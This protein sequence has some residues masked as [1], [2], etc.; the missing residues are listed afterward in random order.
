MSDLIEHDQP[1]NVER[2]L[3]TGPNNTPISFKIYQDIYHQI[4]GKTEEISKK[5]SRSILIEFSDIEQLHHKVM[6]LREIHNVV[7]CNETITIFHD[8]E[9]K[10]NFTS[11]EKF[12]LYNS[13]SNSPTTSVVLQYNF[14]II[15]SGLNTPR[16][17]VIKVRLVSRAALAAQMAGEIPSYMRGRILSMLTENTA[18][19][20]IEYSDYIVAR[21]YL[22]AFDEWI[23]GCN[24]TEKSNLVK[25]LQRK[26]HLFKLTVPMVLIAIL[27][28]FANAAIPDF[29]GIG[30]NSQYAARFLV[31]YA[32]AAY[33]AVALGAYL[34]SFMEN[35][36]DS[37][38]ILS[39][40]KI[41]KGDESLIREFRSGTTPV[42]LKFLLGAVLTVVLG[43]IACKL[44]RII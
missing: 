18:E 40:I 10:E 6:Q 2:I 22:E 14:S 37:Y 35:A 31:M 4:T 15:P 34:G 43:V 16:E 44:D 39:Y 1:G 20:K 21:G 30:K 3:H 25:I 11:F 33:F 9:R 28:Y 41:N 26:S 23:L 7:A 24:H 13:S 38:P 32:S 5:Y 29:F 17:Y 36:I 8:A 27:T 19:I 42:V 12:R